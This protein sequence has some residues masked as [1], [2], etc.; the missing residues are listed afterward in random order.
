[1]AFGGITLICREHFLPDVTYFLCI[2]WR[3]A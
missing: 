3:I 1:M 2:A